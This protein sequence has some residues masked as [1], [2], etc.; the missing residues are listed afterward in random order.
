MSLVLVIDIITRQKY[1]F[2]PHI[3]ESQ[4]IWSLHFCNSQFGLY[5]FKLRVNSAPT[6]NS[7]TKNAYMVNGVLCWHTHGKKYI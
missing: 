6:V 1:H 2:G 7:L 3:L 5:Y 4:S